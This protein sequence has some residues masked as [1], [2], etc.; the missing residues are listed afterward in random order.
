MTYQG[1]KNLI[2]QTAPHLG[3]NLDSGDPFTFSPGCWSYLLERFCVRSVLDLGSGLGEASYY[4]YSKGVAVIAVDGLV[5]NVENATYPTLCIDLTRDYVNT[6]VDL[7]HC[8]EV[9]E[10]IK[11]EYVGNIIKSFQSGKFVCMTH[12]FP[13][14]GGHHHVNEQPSEYW[15]ELMSRNGF[16]LLQEDTSR[17]RKIAQQDKALYLSMS[18]MI[19]RNQRRK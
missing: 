15:I 12:A 6:K 5:D 18:G 7:V 17:I 13:G 14:Q 10:H 11:E 3:G 8:Q 16:I 9:V 4:F 2:S 1:L 19:F